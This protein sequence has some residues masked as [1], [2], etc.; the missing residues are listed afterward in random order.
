MED[1]TIDN[2]ADEVVDD[3]TSS[4]VVMIMIYL[5]VN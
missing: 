3:D 2:D 1:E 5:L 4:N